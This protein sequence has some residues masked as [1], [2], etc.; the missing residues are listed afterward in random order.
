MRL[1]DPQKGQIFLDG[2][3]IRTITQESLRKNIALIPQEPALFHRSIAENIRYSR[4]DA[5][6][7]EIQNVAQSSLA[8]PFISQLREGYDTMVG[9]RGIKLSGGQRQRIAI[10]RT[11]CRLLLTV[12]QPLQN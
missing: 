9:E 10:A 8:H 3:D 6:D 4:F 5:A 1:Y 7:S 11:H 2:K 12:F